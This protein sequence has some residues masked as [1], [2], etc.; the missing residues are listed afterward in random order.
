MPA[1]N[2]DKPVTRKLKVLHLITQFAVGGATE[3]AIT[4]CRLLSDA[5][6][7]TRIL[8]G[9]TDPGQETLHEYAKSAG[10]RVETLASMRRSIHPIHDYRCYIDLVK[11]MRLHKFDIVHTHSSKAGFLGRMAAAKASVPVILHNIHGWGHHDNMGRSARMVYVHAERTAAKVTDRLLVVANAN[12]EKG[13][14]D[15]I[16]TRDQYETVYNGIDLDRFIQ[17]DVDVPQL[18]D[19][20]GI[21]K[22]AMVVGTVSRLA[23]Q[24]A[25]D[26]FLRMA[27]HIHA[28]APH[29][30]FVYV[31]GGPLEKQFTATIAE[32][33]LGN[34]VHAL[35]YRSDVPE[36]LR[37]FD[38]FVL[39]SLWEGL[40]IVFAQAMCA[41]LPI[42]AT[43][44]DGAPEAIKDGVNGFLVQPKKPIEQATRVLELL[45]NSTLRKSMGSA[46][47]ARVADQFAERSMVNHIQRI[48]DEI[49]R[50][51]GIID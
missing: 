14:K 49:A 23:P 36:L 4:T 30:H 35:G 3:P 21:P 18:K 7:A 19:S 22:D 27:A 41:N 8:A 26:D 9:E 38:V 6:Y 42:V 15:G 48:Y 25:P 51:K 24:K 31:G 29:V 32:L 40:P 5:G 43:N 2:N 33:G 28:S 47:A 10:V 20:L 50:S 37:V 11:Y 16:G 44:V 45:L 17:V 34:V 46:G 1:E 12:A 13:L 39:T